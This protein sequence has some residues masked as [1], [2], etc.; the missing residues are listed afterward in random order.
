[1]L[2]RCQ[3]FPLMLL[4]QVV[5]RSRRGEFQKDIVPPSKIVNKGGRTIP[6]CWCGGY[7]HGGGCSESLGLVKS[8][9]GPTDSSVKLVL[10]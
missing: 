5:E 1:M 10:T 4:G 2:C 3:E 9:L 8:E 7:G 6:R